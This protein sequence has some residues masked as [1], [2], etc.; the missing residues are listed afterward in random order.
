MTTLQTF[1]SPEEFVH[2]LIERYA[3]RRALEVLPPVI[4]VT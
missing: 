1:I 4:L 3:G 2:K